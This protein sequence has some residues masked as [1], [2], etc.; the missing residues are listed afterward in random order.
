MQVYV[1]LGNLEYTLILQL[2]IMS[3][4]EIDLTGWF[5][6]LA[7]STLNILYEVIGQGNSI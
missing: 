4:V 6:W 7:L 5:L 3:K 2:I 1:C